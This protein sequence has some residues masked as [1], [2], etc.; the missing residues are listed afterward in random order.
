MKWREIQEGE[1]RKKT[2]F[3]LFPTWSPTSKS[4]AWLETVTMEQVYGWVGNLK[5]RLMWVNVREIRP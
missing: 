1:R 2:Y 3:A 5:P 4:Y